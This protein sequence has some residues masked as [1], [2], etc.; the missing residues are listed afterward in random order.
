MVREE[1]SSWSFEVR[2]PAQVAFIAGGYTPRFFDLAG[3]T[4][5]LAMNHARLEAVVAKVMGDQA[6]ASLA[7]VGAVGPPGIT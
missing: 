2:I 4:R 3:A 1:Y 5:C 6:G 7:E